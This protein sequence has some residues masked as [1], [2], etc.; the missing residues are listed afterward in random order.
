MNSQVLAP[1]SGTS[2]ESTKLIGRGS[3][4]LRGAISHPVDLDL[5]LRK[6]MGWFDS[7]MGGYT[8]SERIA[9]PRFRKASSKSVAVVLRRFADYADRFPEDAR[10]IAEEVNKM[11]DELLE[12]D[13]FGT[14]G[15]I[16]P[17]GDHRD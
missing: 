16:D 13:F 2:G 1:A 6:L 3:T 10:V 15:Q 5:T 14:E 8:T 12:D 9:M 4:P 11:L 17:R 7:S